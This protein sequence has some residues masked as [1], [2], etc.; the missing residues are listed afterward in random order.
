MRTEFSSKIL[1]GLIPASFSN[2]EQVAEAKANVKYAS[3]KL[4]ASLL[5]GKEKAMFTTIVQYMD[6]TGGI[7]DESIF[8]SI[9]ID[10]RVSPED[11]AEYLQMYRTLQAEP[12]PADK[13]RYYISRHVNACRDVRLAEAL[14]SSMQ[15]LSGQTDQDQGGYEAARE[16]LRK[17]LA[18]LDTYSNSSIPKG[19]IRDEYTDIVSDA[20]PSQQD[21]SVGSLTGFSQVDA[22][23]MG[24]QKGELWVVGAY[25]GEGKSQALM[26]MSYYSSVYQ[27][28]NNVIISAEMPKDQYRRRIIVRHSMNA[29]FGLEDGIDYEKV[30]KKQLTPEE[31]AA[32]KNVAYDFTHN[33]A[34]GNYYIIQVPHN[35]TVALIR[36]ELNKVQAMFN[37]DGVYIDYASIL[38]PSRNRGSRREEV[39]EILK[40]IK[41]LALDFND[42]KGLFVCTAWQITQ[43]A[44]EKAER[45]GFYTLRDFSETSGATRTADCIMWLLRREQEIVEHEV[46]CGVLKYRDG[47]SNMKFNLYEDYRVSYLA[48]IDDGT[49]VQVE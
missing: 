48:S 7:P 31:F 6:A 9:L 40:D 28:R 26:N 34:Y 47:D 17:E 33:P 27:K 45:T 13:F 37:V 22:L 30:K 36:A 35:A 19:N 14:A 11:T 29:A 16:I 32:F 18:F 41:Q 25:T 43:N 15:T 49:S 39:D 2:M 44:R 3:D 24:G 5:D 4:N 1:A 20:N 21:L 10:N 23:T 38:Q 46:R 8:S 12:V 42:G